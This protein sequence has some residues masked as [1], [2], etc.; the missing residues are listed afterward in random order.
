MSGVDCC[1]NNVKYFVLFSTVTNMHHEEEDSTAGL[2]NA[3]DNK[4]QLSS[5]ADDTSTVNDAVDE[6]VSDTPTTAKPKCRPARLKTTKRSQNEST[7][8]EREILH[9]IKSANEDEPKDADGL[10]AF[11]RSVA[12]TLRTMDRRHQALAKIKIQQVMMEV[13]FAESSAKHVR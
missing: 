4:S 13:E 12:A 1:H 8:T 10:N 11:G 7:V 9:A 3:D 6:E 5:D 2:S